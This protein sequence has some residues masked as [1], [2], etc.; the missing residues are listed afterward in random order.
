VLNVWMSLSRKNAVLAAP[1]LCVSG[2]TWRG[3]ANA[4]RRPTRARSSRNGSASEFRDGVSR[5]TSPLQ[6]DGLKFH[7]RPV[8]FPR[9][10]PS[11]IPRTTQVST[12][13]SKPR[14]GR[15]RMA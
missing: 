7:S 6:D 10:I 15:I 14:D 8:H 1:A 5:F 13:S 11:C 12:L 9:C 2:P 3:M 4:S